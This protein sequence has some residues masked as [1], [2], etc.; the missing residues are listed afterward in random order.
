MRLLKIIVACALI[1]ASE[2]GRAYSQYSH[3]VVSQSALRESV[4]ND[5]LQLT[6]LGLG[7]NVG[8]QA[9]RLPFQPSPGSTYPMTP[10]AILF[11][12]AID[13]DAGARSFNHFFDPQQRGIPL[14]VV[15]PLGHASPDWAL[16]S[17]QVFADQTYS[18]RDAKSYFRGALMAPSQDA[19]QGNLALLFYSLGHV[20][21]HL[22]DMAQ[23]QHVRNDDHCDDIGCKVLLRFRPSSFEE[24]V[25]QK[26]R[27]LPMSGYRVADHSTFLSPRDY[28]QG[29]GRGI[30]EFTSANFLSVRTN[31]RLSTAAASIEAQ[32]DEKH[33]SP[34]GQDA[35]IAARNIND[36][37]VFGPVT[38]EQTLDG[39]ISFVETPVVDKYL[40]T[41]ETNPRSSTLSIF[42]YDLVAFGYAEMV[43]MYG[44]TLNSLN[45]Q[46][47]AERL[48]PR[49]AAYSTGLLNYFFRGR[50]EISVPAS[51]VFSVVDHATTK[52]VGE[53]FTKFKVRLR[54]ATP[55]GAPPVATPIPIHQEMAN[56]TLTLVAKYYL[57][58]CYTPD[59]LGEFNGATDLYGPITRNGCFYQDYFGGVETISVSQPLVGR[60][61]SR[62]SPEEFTF[63]LSAQ[64]IPIN[65]H[66]LSVQIVYEGVLGEEPDAVVVSGRNISEPTWFSIINGSDW[67]AIDG[68]FYT[69][70]QI[71]N[72][73]ALLARVGSGNFE[74]ET[75]ANTEFLVG[76]IPVTQRGQVPARGF[77]RIAML[78]DAEIQPPLSQPPQIAFQVRAGFP[79]VTS[80][81]A[82]SSVP[83]PPV[84]N[85]LAR[86]PFTLTRVNVARAL[87]GWRQL[88]FFKRVGTA[89]P[90]G[91]LTA[92][93]M[94][95]SCVLPDGQ[96]VCVPDPTPIAL[97]AQ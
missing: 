55:D 40:G 92:I 58:N 38:P 85:Q 94:E 90:S 59:L 51:G 3:G 46:A 7:S 20:V 79:S 64:P 82:A 39:D 72:D 77:H 62:E 66:D 5:P 61:L 21:H 33:P 70:D 50:I 78:A 26:G 45:Y 32:A 80:S 57:N 30:S 97:A 27:Q 69:P 96:I 91:V 12:G 48:L 71:R 88:T 87:P 9:Y 18:Y 93:P 47:A 8:D 19:R 53:G 81:P 34:S 2:Q 67:F 29:E 44:F 16:E 49:A 42:Y 31:F 75:L 10:G 89:P 28:W 37:D 15:A 73:P 36:S 76:G 22:Q 4:A 83:T 25:F 11:Q 84:Q 13:E 24:Y 1:V 17:D 86:A 41:T 60:S 54:N 95:P 52:A 6:V 23:P 43:P 63:D 65:A 56:G 14:T 74:Q 68:K 35:T